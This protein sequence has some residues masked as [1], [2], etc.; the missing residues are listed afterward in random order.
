MT[1]DQHD[2]D[3]LKAE[4][5]H[6]YMRGDYAVACAKAFEAI[7]TLQASIAELTRKVAAADLAV[8]FLADQLIEKGELIMALRVLLAKSNW[9]E[10]CGCGN[11]VAGYAHLPKCRRPK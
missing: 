10:F 3:R 6:Y 11:D 4:A 2:I 5:D 7:T 8:E 1:T 9:C